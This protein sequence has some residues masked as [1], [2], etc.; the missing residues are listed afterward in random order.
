MKTSTKNLLLVMQLPSWWNSSS[1]LE[2]PLSTILKY[3]R[4]IKEITDVSEAMCIYNWE[5]GTVYSSYGNTLSAGSK[6]IVKH[7]SGNG[8]LSVYVCSSNNLKNL[9]DQSNVSNYPPSSSISEPDGYQWVKIFN[10]DPSNKGNYIKIPS[11]NKM[12]DTIKTH[13]DS[14]CTSETNGKIGYCSLY[15][16]DGS[17]G[18]LIGSIST[19]CIVCNKIAKSLADNTIIAKFLI[20][21]DSADVSIITNKEKLTNILDTPVSRTDFSISTYK[22]NLSSGLSAGCIF[23]VNID[24][25][26]LYT[27]VST[28]LTVGIIGS[29]SG[30]DVELLYS[31]VVGSTGNICGINLV[32]GGMGYQSDTRATIVGLVGTSG[33]DL[34]NAINLIVPSDT[35][36]ISDISSIFNTK[37]S[38]SGEIVT[39]IS[40][41]VNPKTES[42]SCNAYALL[43]NQTDNN[44]PPNITG[45][46]F[47]DPSTV[48]ASSSLD[49]K[50][51]FNFIRK[52]E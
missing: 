19:D 34:E 5:K 14:F 35:T 18:K 38:F 27:N 50:Y 15:L 41:E 33:S 52:P 44:L 30:A 28:G 1:P 31:A 22:N 25:D 24:P 3:P 42:I 17:V 49:Q 36:N 2:I 39:L 46:K 26:Y 32:K 4:I 29:G 9:K 12:V 43:T 7:K 10:I 6:S 48:N 37:S 16:N 20:T 47:F 13:E 40:A 8:I 51:K 23:S 11:Y 21:S 45:V